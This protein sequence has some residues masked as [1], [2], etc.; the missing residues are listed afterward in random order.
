MFEFSKLIL[1]VCLPLVSEVQ[2]NDMN[3]FCCSGASASIF[4]SSAL[5]IFPEVSV[6]VTFAQ[7]P[8]S[9]S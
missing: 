9:L 1:S 5:V 6:D 2:F 4:P 8:F 3:L 7:L